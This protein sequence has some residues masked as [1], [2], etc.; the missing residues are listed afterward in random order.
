MR[1]LRREQTRV[2]LMS[3]LSSANSHGKQ[4]CQSLLRRPYNCH[5][6]RRIH[7]GPSLYLQGAKTDSGLEIDKAGLTNGTL[8][9]IKVASNPGMTGNLE[10]GQING[11]FSTVGVD[12]SVDGAT[13][14][15][16][17]R[18]A[19][20]P[21][22]RALKMAIGR[23]RKPSTSSPPGPIPMGSAVSG[24]SR[25]ATHCISWCSMRLG[26]RSITAVARLRW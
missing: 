25:S 18:K 24:L 2:R 6:H 22:L 5:R 17:S 11:T 10:S 12:A 13:L 4:P 15:A 20:L 1:S 23:M 7:A 8:A 26:V 14:Q 3:C 16:N 19:A 21:S 9:G